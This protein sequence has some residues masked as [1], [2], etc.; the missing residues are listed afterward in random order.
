M[1]RDLSREEGVTVAIVTHDL[2]LA[3]RTDRVVR[4]PDGRVVVDH[5]AS[6]A[7]A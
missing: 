7:A 4:L 5:A 3:A 6:E 1:L 2:D